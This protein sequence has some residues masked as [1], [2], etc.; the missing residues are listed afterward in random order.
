M[1]PDRMGL[2]VEGWGIRFMLSFCSLF[3]TAKCLLFAEMTTFTNIS[4]ASLVDHR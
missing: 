1:T 4:I 3:K 2:V